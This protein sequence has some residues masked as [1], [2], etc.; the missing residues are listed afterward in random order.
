MMGGRRAELKMLWVV[1]CLVFACA[2]EG[3][4]QQL[5]VWNSAAQPNET[6]DWLVKPIKAKA[7]ILKSADGK[8]LILWNGLV[9]RV[10]RLQPNLAC[11]DYTNLY[12]VRQLLRAVR[13]EARLTINSKCYNIGGLIG[14]K[15][16]AY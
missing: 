8:D 9:K 1:C 13:E 10:F 12:T 2:Q 4:A 16:N 5:P 15:E 3:K 7:Q 11:I 6:D 14:Q